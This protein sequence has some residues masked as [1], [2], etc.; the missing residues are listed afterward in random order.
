VLAGYTCSYS[1]GGADAWIVKIDSQGVVQWQKAFGGANSDEA[2]AIQQTADGGYI[3]AGYTRSSGSSG[4]GSADM[5]IFKL[6]AIGTLEWE[7]FFGGSN[8]EV[9]YSVKE[10]RDGGYAAV[11]YTSSYGYGEVNAYL[12]KMHSNGEAE[13]SK[14]YGGTGDN[15]G[16][17][18][19]QTPDNGYAI[20]GYTN[21][22]GAG[23]NNMWVVKVDSSGVE[24]WNKYYGTSGND[25]AYSIRNTSDGGYIIAGSV[26]SSANLMDVLIYKLNAYG[27]PVWNKTYG[28]GDSEIAWSVVQTSSGGYMIAGSKDGANSD[29]WVLSL[30]GSGN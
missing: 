15:F 20:A 11:G 16:R 19:I 2:Y 29:I 14:T 21:S 26:Y 4:H 13:W 27:S 5:W 22:Y 1:A 17:D 18:I 28:N 10:T 30:D 7:K 25:Q 12:V 3:V 9:A 23:D 6:N 24:K 8:N